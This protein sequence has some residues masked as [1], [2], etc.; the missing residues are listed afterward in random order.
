MVRFLTWLVGKRRPV[1]DNDT[2]LAWKLFGPVNIVCQFQSEDRN[3]YRPLIRPMILVLLSGTVTFF[4]LPKAAR[5]VRALHTWYL[6][7]NFRHHTEL[8]PAMTY[9]D[10]ILD[11]P[12]WM[13]A[14]DVRRG[15]DK[16][17]WFLAVTL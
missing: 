5:T 16:H 14:A 6:P 4:A 8:A 9:E 17:A 3:D 1:E 12:K 7:K 10:A 11:M 13:S 15:T 2:T